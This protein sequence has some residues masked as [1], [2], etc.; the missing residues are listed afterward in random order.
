MLWLGSDWYEIRS[1]PMT[2][3]ACHEILVAAHKA[4]LTAPGN[5]LIYCERSE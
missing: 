2:R 3:E 4:K 1:Q 5:V